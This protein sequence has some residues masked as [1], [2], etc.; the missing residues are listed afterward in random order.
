MAN[1][2]TNSNVSASN[3]AASTDTGSAEAAAPDVINIL[4]GIAPE[5]ALAALR[6]QR[7]DVQT[8]TQNS[9]A[10]LLNPTDVGGLSLIERHLVGLRIGTLNRNSAV[11]TRHREQLRALGADPVLITATE[12]QGEVTG[13]ARLAAILHFTDTLT[14]QPRAATPA[15]IE[16]LTQAGLSDKD[17]VTLGQLVAYLAYQVRLLAGLRALEGIAGGAK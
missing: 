7:G 9:D 3:V 15:N 8:Y 4:A 11:A 5:S 13:P 12:A 6:A 2:S 16:R 17:I 14:N 1:L 10:A